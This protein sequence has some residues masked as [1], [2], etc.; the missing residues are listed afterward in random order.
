MHLTRG[1]LR[2]ESAEEV[3]RGHSSEEARGNTGGAKGRRTKRERSTDRPAT[4]WRAVGRNAGGVATAA[5]TFGGVAARSGWIPR[6]G[7]TRPTSQRGGAR[8]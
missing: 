1:D 8:R 4:E 6:A 2:G 7:R 5:T 3:S